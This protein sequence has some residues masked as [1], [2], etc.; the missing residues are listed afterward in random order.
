[1]THKLWQICVYMLYIRRICCV[2]NMH[3][4][5]YIVINDKIHEIATSARSLQLFITTLMVRHGSALPPKQSPAS[6]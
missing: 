4:H 5:S 1:M 3:T 2:R 6:F